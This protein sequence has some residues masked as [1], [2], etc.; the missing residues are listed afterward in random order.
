MGLGAAPELI[1][2]L[3][4]HDVAPRRH[5]RRI[6]KVGKLDALNDNVLVRVFIVNKDIVCFDIY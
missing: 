1:S 3:G 5:I 4:S 2:D 6:L